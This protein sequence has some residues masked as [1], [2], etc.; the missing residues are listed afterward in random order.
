MIR[1]DLPQRL[2]ADKQRVFTQSYCRFQVNFAYVSD[3]TQFINAIRPVCPC[4]EIAGGPP[5]PPIPVNKSLVPRSVFIQMPSV[6]ASTFSAITTSG[7]QRPP[8]PARA[9]SMV[10]R[11]PHYSSSQEELSQKASH[12]PPTSSSDL[13]LAPS[14]DPALP[15][16]RFDM[17][18]QPSSSVIHEMHSSRFTAHNN[19]DGSSSTYYSLPASSQLEPTPSAA[20]F[21]QPSQGPAEEKEK[22][23]EA[24]LDS[25]REDTELYSLTRQELENLVSVVVREKGF[26]KLVGFRVSPSGV[27]FSLW[28]MN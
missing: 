17:S 2:H 1:L 4:K 12:F 23:W 28:V 10:E 19:K 13:S 9:T 21:A 15:A 27:F 18:F 6:C 26:P 8:L 16:H 3:A 11:N 24:F 25:L 22:M 14:S 5:P 20:T 7:P